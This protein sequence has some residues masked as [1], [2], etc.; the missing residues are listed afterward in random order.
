M[1]L[2][3]HDSCSSFFGRH[4][5]SLPVAGSTGKKPF[6][7]VVGGHHAKDLGGRHRAFGVHV[8]PPEHGFDAVHRR[9]AGVVAQELPQLR[10]H[11]ALYRVVGGFPCASELLLQLHER[12]HRLVLHQA[13]QDVPRLAEALV[14]VLAPPVLQ[15]ELAQEALPPR[16]PPGVLGEPRGGGAR[17][18]HLQEPLGDGVELAPALE[19]RAGGRAPLHRPE[20]VEEAPL[21][22]RLR[23]YDASRLGEAGRSVGDGHR[24]GR[25]AEH[26]RRP[27]LRVLASRQMP[28]E[29]VPA[30]ARYE[31]DD[32][33]R[34]PDAVQEDDVADLARAGGDGPY[35]PELADAPPEGAALPR[36]I[37]LG[38]L[39]EQPRKELG[40][41]LRFVVYLSRRG[42][43]ARRASEAR[44]PG[45]GGP[46]P[47][48]L[49]AADGASWIV[50][51]SPQLLG[52]FFQEKECLNWDVKRE[53][54]THSVRAPS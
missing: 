43:P 24:G 46:V 44:R 47:L 1:E 49:P 29:H 12:E 21:H 35:P 30:G 34:D 16:A 25:D 51:R 54:D 13:V 26:E 38:I 8:A 32:V 39:R 27:G 50:H 4:A 33:P 48:R 28:R 22:A 17:V 3:P 23:P 19:L 7:I 10:V 18:L 36:H 45:R 42:S 37:L 14:D 40:K 6:D 31:H 41:P 20:D 9:H 53:S 2:A 11:A 52:N 5:V 15:G